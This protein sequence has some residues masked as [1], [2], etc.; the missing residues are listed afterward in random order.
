LL[1]RQNAHRLLHARAIRTQWRGWLATCS[2]SGSVRD[3]CTPEL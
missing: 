1:S 3:V 2:R